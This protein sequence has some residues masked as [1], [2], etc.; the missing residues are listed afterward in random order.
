MKNGYG[1]GATGAQ[2]GRLAPNPT[3]VLAV[4]S[5]SQEFGEAQP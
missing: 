1:S 5:R 2:G 3:L 4:P